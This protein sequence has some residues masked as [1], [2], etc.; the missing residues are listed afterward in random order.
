MRYRSIWFMVMVFVLPILITR[1]SKSRLDGLSS[2]SSTQNVFGEDNRVVLDSPAFPFTAIGRLDNGCT[3]TLLAPNLVL[4]AA[5][6]VI[7]S[8]TGRPNGQVSFFRPGYS[9]SNRENKFWISDFWVGT[10]SP[11]ENRTQDFA[12]LKLQTPVTGF[13]SMVIS[14]MPFDHAL[15]VKV[16]L[17]GY[18]N[19]KSKG[20]VLSYVPECQILEKTGVR[21]ASNE[22]SEKYLH[23]CDAVSGVS[24]GPLFW[25][26]HGANQ[27][28]VIGITVSELR[29][30]APSSVYRDSYNRDFANIAVP[31]KNFSFVAAQLLAQGVYLSAST[32]VN[33]AFAMSNPNKQPEN[34]SPVVSPGSQLT[35]CPQVPF[36]IDA[37]LLTLQPQSLESNA[38]ALAQESP[39]WAQLASGRSHQGLY[40]YGSA[41]SNSSVHLCSILNLYRTK[42]MDYATASVQLAP[43]LCSVLSNIIGVQ[44]YTATHGNELL[45]LDGSVHTRIGQSIMRTQYLGRL[46]L[47][48]Q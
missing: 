45:Q 26:N 19:D 38:C 41:L 39:F 32:R 1:C 48:V 20:E 2:E 36:A 42:Q 17:G 16:S 10:Y 11:E 7:N 3:G 29:N 37:Q 12:F 34:S 21:N 27:Y 24:G 28:D 22:T 35:Q 44:Q 31:A 8:K 5:H 47:R 13:G 6:C 9:P 46:I 18:S 30:G 14:S 4:T 33:G 25:Y 43:H 15:P 40:D 23:D